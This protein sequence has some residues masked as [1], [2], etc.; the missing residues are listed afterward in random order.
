MAGIRQ[1]RKIELGKETT[2]GTA[3]TPTTIW[4]GL[5]ALTDGRIVTFPEE[6]IGVIG[7]GDRSYIARVEAT[8]S[9]DST[10]ATFEQLPHLLIAGIAATTAGTQDG[11]GSGY[12]YTY[13][14]P[15]S[16]APS[17]KTY[18]IRAGDN[19][20][21]ETMDYAFVESL[22]LSGNAGEAVMMG[23]E[24]RGRAVTNATFTTTATIPTVETI[25]A[26]SATLALDAASGTYGATPVSSTLISFSVDFS[27]L[28]AAKWTMGAGGSTVGAFDFAYAGNREITGTLQFEHN[29][30][31][32]TEKAAFRAETPRL[33]R[34]KF[35]GSAVTT[36]G[37]TYSKKTL[38]IDLPI[39][40]E[41]FDA[42]DDIDGNSVVTANFRSRYNSTVANAG[43]VIVV[44]NGT[45]SI[46]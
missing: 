5:G 33:M 17:I 36:A 26:S 46:P 41:S 34:L 44:L 38:I 7:G 19:Q 11:T 21:A 8:L 40:Y 22:S 29:A 25:L 43:K 30:T 9:M 15:F 32:V 28:N 27:S 13:T 2:A 39:K 42:L 4:R 18:T 23:A 16:T 10:D 1:L 12:V 3:T 45:T 35:E 20:Q 14:I 24:W 37:T 6:F 31:A